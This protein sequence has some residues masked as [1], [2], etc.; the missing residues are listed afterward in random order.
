MFGNCT[1][2]WCDAGTQA[3]PFDAVRPTSFTMVF[4]ESFATRTLDFVLLPSGELR[5]TNHTHFTDSSGRADYTIVDL[6]RKV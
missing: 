5:L 3:A 6:L 4:V 1:P 2:S